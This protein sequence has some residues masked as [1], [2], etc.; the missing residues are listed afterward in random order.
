MHLSPIC[1]G[2]KSSLPGLPWGQVSP[3]LPLHGGPVRPEL[4]R[5]YYVMKNNVLGSHSPA[6]SFEWTMVMQFQASTVPVSPRLGELALLL[7]IV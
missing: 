1:P 4:K 3:F 2:L 5:F 7:S 6:L